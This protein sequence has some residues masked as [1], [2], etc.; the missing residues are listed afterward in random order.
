MNIEQFRNYC[1]SLGPDVTEKTPFGKFSKKFESTLVFYVD[2]HMFASCDMDDFT[3]INFR[4]SPDEMEYL[5]NYEYDL[6]P[7]INPILKDWIKVRVNDKIPDS[8]LYEMV[9]NAYTIV[10]N[11]HRKTGR[12][13]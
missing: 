11:L 1:L 10:K 4:V 13:S 5:S 6:A 2:N 3:Y 12:T 7:T 8:K 9:L